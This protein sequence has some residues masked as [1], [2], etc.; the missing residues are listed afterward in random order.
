VHELFL[1]QETWA[2]LGQKLTNDSKNEV[3]TLRMMTEYP[4]KRT[5]QFG[6]P[7]LG[8]CVNKVLKERA[9]PTVLLALCWHKC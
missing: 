1:D 6:V 4:S 5:C 9:S 8:T 2:L 3:T 7:F